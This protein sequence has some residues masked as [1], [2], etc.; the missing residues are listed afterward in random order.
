MLDSLLFHIYMAS[1]ARGGILTLHSDAACCR[2]FCLLP[3]DSSLLI[4]WLCL[5]AAP[6]YLDMHNMYSW[7]EEL[8]KSRGVTILILR[9]ARRQ[10]LDGTDKSRRETKRQK[11][12]IEISLNR[13][14]KKSNPAP[15]KNIDFFYVVNF[16]VKL[17]NTVGAENQD[18]SRVHISQYCIDAFIDE[19]MH[20]DEALVSKLLR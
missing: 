13:D 9:H 6:R 8:V 19:V 11:V 5:F 2:D 4:F 16:L 7:W 10:Y 1:R 12:H 3:E 14:W 17:Q 15:V 20:K 18:A